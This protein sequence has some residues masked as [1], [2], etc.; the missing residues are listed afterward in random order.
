MTPDAAA[1]TAGCVPAAGG[2]WT[3]SRQT[4]AGKRVMMN[5][6]DKDQWP[7]AVTSLFCHFSL[8]GGGGRNPKCDLGTET[9]RDPPIG[10]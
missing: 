2:G 10:C 5:C 9:A 8:E 7:R 1:G 4:L 3:E 6:T